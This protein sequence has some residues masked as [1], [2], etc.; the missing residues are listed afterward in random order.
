MRILALLLL[1]LLPSAMALDNETSVSVEPNQSANLSE[2]FAPIRIDAGSNKDYLDSNG[3]L[4]SADFGF[5]GGESVDRGN[6]DIRKTKDDTLFQTERFGMSGYHFNVSNGTYTV[7]MHF[8]ETSSKVKKTND[9]V[10]N[11]EIE[12]QLFS[13]FD[14]FSQGK[15]RNGKVLQTAVALVND[16]TLD[17]LFSR[18]LEDPFVNG[19]EIVPSGAPIII[20]E[21]VKEEPDYECE[22]IDNDTFTSGLFCPNEQDCNDNEAGINP[23]AGEICG[24]SID[25]DCDGKDT[26]CETPIE[27]PIES[28]QEIS[29]S[30]DIAAGEQETFIFTKEEIPFT[31]VEVSVM[32]AENVQVAV[33][34]VPTNFQEDSI[35]VFKQVEIQVS[36]KNEVH[37]D[38]TLKVPRSWYEENN[39]IPNSTKILRY[40]DGWQ[41]LETK[42]IRFDSVYY[43]F[44]GSTPGFS[45][46]AIVAK[47]F[48]LPDI[49]TS[50]GEKVQAKQEGQK[51]I[52]NPEFFKGNKNAVKT[53]LSFLVVVGGLGLLISMMAMRYLNMAIETKRV[54]RELL[55]Q[56][57][58]KAKDLGEA[59]LKIRE[60]MAR[61]GFEK[62]T[63]E[64]AL[65]DLSAK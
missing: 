17:I 43:Y 48:P 2:V 52:L 14:A 47:I 41:E 61:L 49:L 45:A 54:Q 60:D 23:L 36:A 56:Y 18:I 29:S 4:W 16:G 24:N 6:I 40:H 55:D 13:D 27:Q 11:F 58:I 62:G 31:Q 42:M 15:G 35:K 10:F 19:I 51:I 20:L 22:D 57:I 7:I 38:M 39:A 37:A 1:L 26:A 65:R 59:P 50:D 28:V 21:E 9:R 63:V 5:D 33:T 44:E 8:A 64:R 25:E 12:G 3:N 53:L 46:F 34:E 30:K 32:E